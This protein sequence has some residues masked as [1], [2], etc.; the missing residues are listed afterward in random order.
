M[1]AY[2]SDPVQD[3]TSGSLCIVYVQSSAA[4]AGP[5]TLLAV[6]LLHIPVAKWAPPATSAAI[7]PTGLNLSNS[8]YG[9]VITPAAATD[10]VMTGVYYGTAQWYQ[11]KYSGKYSTISRFGSKDK[12]GAFCMQGSGTTSYFNT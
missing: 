5:T 7:T 1:V 8:K 6:Y 12:I 2:T 11:P 9:I 10:Y 4:G 3:A